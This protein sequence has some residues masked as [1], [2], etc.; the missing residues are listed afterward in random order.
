MVREPGV[1]CSFGSGVFSEAAL[2]PNLAQVKQKKNSPN[3][4]TLYFLNNFSIAFIHKSIKACPPIK[5]K[6]GNQTST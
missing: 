5:P 2:A 4:T 1:Y 6:K 3:K